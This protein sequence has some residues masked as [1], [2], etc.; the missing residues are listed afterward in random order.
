MPAKKKQRTK[1]NFTKSNFTSQ[2]II[3]IAIYLFL[4]ILVNYNIQR[5]NSK[6]MGHR[7]NDR[8]NDFPYFDQISISPTLTVTIIPTVT[9]SPTPTV[10]PSITSTPT[11][12]QSSIITPTDVPSNENSQPT[13]ENSTI[14]QQQTTNTGST[15]NNFQKYIQSI[16]RPS[17]NTR[18]PVSTTTKQPIKATI[19][20]SAKNSKGGDGPIIINTTYGPNTIKEEGIS[21][22]TTDTNQNENVSQNFE[23][24]NANIDKL[25]SEI[26]TGNKSEQLKTIIEAQKI[27]QQTSQI[28]LRKV[29]DRNTLLQIFL[30]PDYKAINVL[31]TEMD[32]TQERILLLQQIQNTITDSVDIKLVNEAITSLQDQSTSLNFYLSIKRGSSGI[33]EKYLNNN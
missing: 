31:Q 23:T 20:P 15:L 19:T 32:K 13:T 22:T 30:G 33:L 7:T 12:T 25:I 9:D 6:V 18:S 10:T 29:E 26:S 16:F 5:N 1:S 21:Q 2:L 3:L 8:E 27:S 17:S 28:Q 4:G 14:S 24:A 11:P